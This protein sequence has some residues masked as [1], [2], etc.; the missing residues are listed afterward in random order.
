MAL[1]SMIYEKAPA[2]VAPCMAD[3]FVQP[4][5]RRRSETMPFMHG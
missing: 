2:R 1:L 3:K 4:D 5:K